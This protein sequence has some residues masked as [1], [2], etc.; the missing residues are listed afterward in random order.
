MNYVPKDD[1][2]ETALPDVEESARMHL[3]RSNPLVRR[4]FEI[5]PGAEIIAV[6]VSRE[7][8]QLMPK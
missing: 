5:F 3:A 7:T 8:R 4:A 6:R 1:P 2:P